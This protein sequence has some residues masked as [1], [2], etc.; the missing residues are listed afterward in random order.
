MNISNFTEAEIAFLGIDALNEGF[1]KG[2][3]TP[4]DVAYVLL[5]RIRRLNPLVNAVIDLSPEKTL[6]MAEASALRWQAGAPLSMLDGVPVTIKDLSAIKGWPRWRGGRIADDTPMTYD[7]PAVARLR[8]AGAVF[9][10]RTATPE[11]GT[12]VVTRSLRYGETLNPWDV[13]KTPGGSSGG[14]AAALAMGFGPIALGSDGAGSLRI[15]AS[16]TNLVGVK[17]GFGRVPAFPPDPDMPHSVVG[18]MARTVR[19]AAIMLDVLSRPEPRDPYAWPLPFEM[20]DLSGDLTGLKI[21]FSGRMGCTAPLVDAEVDA[22]VAEAAPLLSAAGASLTDAAPDWPL[23]PFTPFEVFWVTA[24]MEALRQTPKDKHVLLDPI[25]HQVAARGA[26][27]GIGTLMQAIEDRTKIAAASKAFFNRYDLL[28]GPVMP[29]PAYQ[30]GR[31]VPDG[32][33]PADWN[34][35]PYTYPWNMTGQPALSV[36]VGFTAAGLP[37]GVQI[38]GPMGGEALLLRAAAAIERA[39]PLCLRHPR[40]A[41]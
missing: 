3:F 16:H 11:A 2:A 12:K 1:R 8:E 23:D 5:D 17:P 39:R 19:D 10:G 15:P 21:A 27:Y 40:I 7:T 37:V 25:I 13:T 30:V 9:L 18:P 6:A 36:P 29:V 31:D 34:W 38:V 32:F 14:A 33:E 28:V 35:C 4:V 22:L 41:L 24:C 20:P 26:E